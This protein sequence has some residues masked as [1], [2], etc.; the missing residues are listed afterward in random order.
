MPRSAFHKSADICTLG[1]L[2]VQIRRRLHAAGIEA[3]EREA[4]WLIE[5]A[6]S[7]SRSSQIVDRSRP[8][9]EDE[10]AR[11]DLLHP[12]ALVGG[13]LPFRYREDVFQRRPVHI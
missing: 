12:L 4:R 9:S 10:M 1:P 5:H 6:L 2:M 8:V 3:A 13:P 11:V 7:M